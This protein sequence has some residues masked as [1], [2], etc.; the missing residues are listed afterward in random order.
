MSFFVWWFWLFL[1]HSGLFLN[2]FL[3]LIRIQI[4]SLNCMIDLFLFST[5]YSFTALK[6]TGR[7]FFLVLIHYTCNVKILNGLSLLVWWQLLLEDLSRFIHDLFTSRSMYLGNF[8]PSFLK[9]LEN[10]I[11]LWWLHGYIYKMHLL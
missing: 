5:K 3:H 9:V 4:N 7:R 10:W 2:L 11:F 1:R 8:E 6:L